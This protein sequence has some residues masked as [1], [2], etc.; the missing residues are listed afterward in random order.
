MAKTL[1]WVGSIGPV[2][3]AGLQRFV[4]RGDAVDA[5]DV[6]DDGRWAKT[7]PE[8]AAPGEEQPTAAETAPQEVKTDG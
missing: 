1:Y 8:D 4:R 3:H 2:W 6:V 5:A 7:K